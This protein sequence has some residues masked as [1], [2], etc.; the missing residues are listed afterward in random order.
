M[1][2]ARKWLRE[3]CFAHFTPDEALLLASDH[4]KQQV[5]FYSQYDNFE[6]LF[7]QFSTS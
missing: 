1:V 7:L 6:L 2:A 5:L 3:N 4:A